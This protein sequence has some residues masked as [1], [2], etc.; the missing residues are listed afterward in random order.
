MKYLMI[1]IYCF[2][3]TSLKASENQHQIYGLW[4]TEDQKAKIE[5]NPCPTNSQKMCG[6]IVELQEPLDPKTGKEK[7]DKLNP[8][9]ALKDRPLLGLMNLTD[10]ISDPEDPNHWTDGK[11]YSPREGE[12]YSCELTLSEANILNV[13]GYIGLP[14]LGKTQTWTR[15]TKDEKLPSVSESE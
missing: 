4:K 13:R 11:I 10:F 8:D 12:T 15:T 1:L 14:L 7:T 3:F 6:V 9:P 5:I 2:I